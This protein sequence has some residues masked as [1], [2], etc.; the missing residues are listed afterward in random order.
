MT[1][2][3]I[4]FCAVLKRFCPLQT[5]LSKVLWAPLS[6]A[7]IL[8]FI[9]PVSSFSQSNYIQLD[10]VPDVKSRFSAGCS[11]VQELAS[12][13]QHRGIDVLIFGDHNKRSLEYGFSPLEKIFKK[14]EGRSSVLASGINVYLAEISG[15]DKS[16]KKTLLIPSVESAPFYYWTGSLLEENLVANNWGKHLW[17]VGLE[18][19]EDFEAIPTLNSAFSKRYVSQFQGG[20]LFFGAL[21][22][23]SL[24]LVF[25][26]RKRFPVITFLALIVTSLF[27][28]N[29]HPFVSSPYN[30]YD[31][32]RGVEPYQEVIDYVVSKGGMVFWNHVETGSQGR[33]GDLA[34][35]TPPHPED[36]LLTKNYSGFQAVNDTPISATE[37]GKEWD[38]VLLQY[39]RG[40]RYK[41]V[42]G[43]GANDFHCEEQDGHKLGS[44]RTVVLVKEKNQTE[45]LDAM[46]TGRMYGVRKADGKGRLSLDDFRIVDR[47][48]GRSVIMGQE[49]ESSDYPD[50]KVK[51]SSNF[52]SA[53]KIRFTLIR[54]GKV[55]KR[56]LASLPY[57]LNWRD[58]AVAR[59][60]KVYYRL[61]A[62]TRSGNMI[63]S[64]PVF[65]KF[66]GPSAQ[67]ASLTQ[68]PLPISWDEKKFRFPEPVAP[69]KP[70]VRAPEA[71][72]I[73]ERKSFD[74]LKA[75]FP[76]LEEPEIL[77]TPPVTQEPEFPF[78][79]PGNR[80]I[81][82]R[83]VSSLINGLSLKEG[84]GVNFAVQEKAYKG[85]KLLVVSQTDIFSDNK[86]WLQVEKDGNIFFV[87]EG[88]VQ[89]E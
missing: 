54:N 55:V 80:A 3:S 38:Q 86:P 49:L 39:I 50:I 43:Y 23:V 9:S 13:G 17:V 6:W 18:N 11:S 66:K 35:K 84:P 47:A 27:F 46:R 87:W 48:T 52:K 45:V 67:V 41:P 51:I 88:F 7:L 56:E 4:N 89:P 42:W 1:N 53:E 10:M 44:V 81:R 8:F 73:P 20:F 34:F 72:S 62:E 63:V 77:K 26:Y 61:A 74:V 83:F 2:F 16:F 85:E 21:F 82:Q 68:N 65:V 30:Q 79:L 14:K 5:R 12:L 31:G 64:N 36:L 40:E 76:D 60:G 59:A 24:I 29:N 22:F 25:L 33:L 19:P 57:V 37:P 71:F 15:N 28:L 69:K 70:R 78:V 32:D 58:Q 75:A